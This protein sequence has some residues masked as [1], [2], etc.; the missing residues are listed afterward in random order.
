MIANFE[1]MEHKVEIDLQDICSYI[2]YLQTCVDETYSRNAWHV[3]LLG[4]YAQSHPTLGPPFDTWVPPPAPFEA[5]T[6]PEDSDFQ[7]K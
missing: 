3:P 4:G 7:E 6:P 2:R 1:R 5:P